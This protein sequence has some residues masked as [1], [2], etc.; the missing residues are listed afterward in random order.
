MSSGRLMFTTC[1]FVALTAM[2]CV[3]LRP[4]EELR[5]ERPPREFIQVGDIQVHATQHGSGAP[6][7][8]IHGFGASAHSWRKV[9][10][11]LAERYRVIALDLLGFGLTDR[12]SGADRYTRASQV[13]LIRGVL[14]ELNVE[15]AHMV[16]HSYGGGI[17]MAFVAEHPDRVRSM[18]LVDSTPPEYP[19][20]R[21]KLF[22]AVRP[23]NWLFVR[24]IALRPAFVRRVMERSF[25]DDALVTDKLLESYRDRLRVEGAVRAYRGLTAPNRDDRQAPPVRIEDLD[26]PALVVWGSEDALVAPEK[27]EEQARLLP[28]YQWATIPETGHA[29][30]EED[31]EAF[32][33]TL[34]PFLA[35]L[36]TTGQIGFR[37]R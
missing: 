30:M 23:L 33:E 28:Q 13:N 24:G 35:Q 3:P 20:N 11:R 12:P 27:A 17:V 9:I 34:M 22:A 8:L 2:A 10:P 14:D 1:L 21:R 31:P 16:G 25:H 15:R 6:V 26:V 18:V 4:L 19:Q 7:V 5:Q 37:G 32:V 36:D 29:P